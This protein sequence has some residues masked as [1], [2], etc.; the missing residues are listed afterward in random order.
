MGEDDASCE[1]V[2]RFGSSNPLKALQ[3]SIVGSLGIDLLDDLVVVNQ[4]RRCEAFAVRTRLSPFV[5]LVPVTLINLLFMRILYAPYTLKAQFQRYGSS[6]A[7][8][9]L[10]AFMPFPE[11]A[12]FMLAGKPQTYQTHYAV[13]GEV[14]RNKR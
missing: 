1:E 7:A 2:M 3:Q 8:T 14:E 12:V 13:N 9:L 6:A 10:V 5:Q 11:A 4:F